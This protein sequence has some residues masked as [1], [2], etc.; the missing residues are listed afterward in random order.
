[1]INKVNKKLLYIVLTILFLFNISHFSICS[2]SYENHLKLE[3]K[4][5]SES[6]KELSTNK[7]FIS[8]DDYNLFWFIQISDTQFLWYD[9]NKIASFYNFL[10]ETYKE[11]DPLFIYHT[12]DLV[13]AYSGLQQNKFE[14]ELYKKAL[15]DNKM[16][17]SIYMDVIGN[18]DA[19]QDPNF[20]YFLNYSMMGRSF[21]T[22]Q[23]SFNKTFD[24]GKYAFIGLNTAKESYNLFEFVFQGFLNSEE[25]NWYENELEKYKECDK[26]FVFGHHPPNYP[27]YYTIQ[28]EESLS[29]KDFY[30]LNEDYNVSYYFCGHTH[31]NAIQHFN[32]LLMIS[33][34]N[35][36]QNNGAYRII[37]LDNDRL[38]TSIETVGVWPQ[39]I[40]TNPSEEEYLFGD[41]N[42]KDEKLRAIAWDPKGIDSVTWSFFD[43]N[44]EHQITNWK[45][46]ERIFA[47]EP[48]WEGNLAFEFH[49]KLMLK[50]QIK[51]HS[52]TK[53][54]TLIYIKEEI[55]NISLLIAIIMTI[56]LISISLFIILY[57]YNEVSKREK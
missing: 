39:A 47:N 19:A 5:G 32:D 33:T 49:G 9:E 54:K 38:S 11:I 18:H 16:N 6:I 15:D 52:G 1:M 12:G 4:S 34:L 31:E 14:W 8:I 57:L 53:F 50:V 23:Y 43:I 13:D 21:N 48:L 22:T 56:G 30:E 45:P 2:Y 37:A 42:V 36:D 3:K 40:I 55:S 24:F 41:L 46:L 29:G 17:A 7:G 26:I 44:G 27:P 35:F 28:S 51:G 20:N 10:N 25:I